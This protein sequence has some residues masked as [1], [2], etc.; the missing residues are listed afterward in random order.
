MAYNWLKLV[1][2]SKQYVTSVIFIFVCVC[3]LVLRFYS[4][5][6]PMG[7]CQVQ[8]VYLAT[9]LLGRVK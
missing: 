5:V 6:N 9:L 8:L 3:L 2:P 1:W 4:P 7:S